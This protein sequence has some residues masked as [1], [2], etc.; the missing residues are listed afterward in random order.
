MPVSGRLLGLMLWVVGAG[1]DPDKGDLGP[2]AGSLFLLSKSSA[3][4][5]YWESETWG[6][7]GG[8]MLLSAPEGVGVSPRRHRRLCQGNVPFR[9]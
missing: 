3:K 8:M 5:R 9:L 7:G 6:D 1:E 2:A 4:I